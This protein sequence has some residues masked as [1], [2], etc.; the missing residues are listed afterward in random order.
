L[1]AEFIVATELIAPT[2]LVVG[3]IGLS[4]PNW[5]V[6]VDATP[7]GLIHRDVDPRVEATLGFG[8]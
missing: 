1:P 5:I 6:G 2:E 4:R 7:S 8:T 3:W